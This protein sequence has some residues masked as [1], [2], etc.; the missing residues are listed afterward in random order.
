MAMLVRVMVAL[1]LATSTA[2]EVAL[3]PSDLEPLVLGFAQGF[4][5]G[6]ADLM[7]CGQTILVDFVNLKDAFVDFK[8]GITT[9]N[10]TKVEGAVHELSTALKAIPGI[11]GACHPLEADLKALIAALKQLHGPKDIVD[12]IL[13]H[14]VVGE[15][16]F[17]ELAAAVKAYKT[18]WDYLTAGENLGK[19]LRGMLVGE[20]QTTPQPP[21]PACMKATDVGLAL[22]FISDNMDALNCSKWLVIEVGDFN[23]A[24]KDL[25]QGLKQMSM[26][27][28]SNALRKFTDAIKDLKNPGAKAACKATET[29]L[30]TIFAV[31]E[32]ITGPKNLVDHVMDNIAADGEQIFG[33]FAAA[34]HAHKNKQCTEAGR[35]MGMAFRRSLIGA[36]TPNATI[37]V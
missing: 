19:A 15:K 27:D 12:H 9:M 17:D 35:D 26:K 29:D 7:T 8:K 2:A 33:E 1:H 36:T 37:I 28:I 31:M 34:A 16:I 23:Q 5:A 25:V 13:D 6:N 32:K 22:G 24:V 21:N 20:N 18:G 14:L 4:I 30:K 10:I 3:P 11:K